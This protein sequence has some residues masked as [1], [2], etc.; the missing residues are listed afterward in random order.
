MLGSSKFAYKSRIIF[1]GNPRCQKW[2]DP[3]G[4]VLGKFGNL[5]KTCLKLAQNLVKPRER[6][7]MSL[8]LP[9]NI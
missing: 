4:Q 8:T 5:P 7:S 2:S 3:E 6:Y 9:S 1:Y